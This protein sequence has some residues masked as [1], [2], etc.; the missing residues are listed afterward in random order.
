MP[1]VFQKTVMPLGTHHTPEGPVQVT[2]ERMRHWVDSF[3]QMRARGIKIPTPWSHHPKAAPV[4]SA[5]DL[6]LDR[7]KWNAGYVDRL[8]TDPHT[9]NLVCTMPPP[10][11]MVVDGGDLVDPVNHTRIGEVSAGIGDWKDGTGK[12]WNDVIWHVALT[13]LPVS[14][15]QDGF[16]LPAT[17]GSD[18]FS[19]TPAGGMIRPASFGAFDSA[20]SNGR[21]RR[22]QKKTRSPKGKKARRAGRQESRR[23]RGSG[24]GRNSSRAEAGRG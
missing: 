16:S 10:P 19:L 7:A 21:N 12:W 20:T 9:G 11:G 3:N 8:D 13:P 1:G 17:T 4:E 24:N 6:A 18:G 22:W 15:G 2:P 14:A 5:E 23:G